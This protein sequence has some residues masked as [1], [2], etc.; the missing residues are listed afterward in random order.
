MR[1]LLSLAALPALFSTITAQNNH[2]FVDY[3]VEANPDLFPQCLAKLNM[4][5]PDC[6]SGPLS[7]NLVCDRSASPH[8]RATALVSLFT[9]EE[10]VNNT[11]NTGFGVPR[12]NLPNYQVWGEALHG[13]GRATFRDQGDFSWATSFPMP[14]STMAALNKT[15]IKQI[16]EIV[17]TQLRAYSNAGLGGI[18]V[19]SPNINTFRHPVWGRGQETPG[20]DPFLASV[21]G[22]EYITA[23]QGSSPDSEENLKIIATAKHFAGYDI[24]SWRNHSRLGNDVQ[25]T[26]QDLSEYYMPPFITAARD[27]RVRSVM[28]SYNAV[29]GLPS[30][31]NKFFLQTLLRE[32]FA[33]VEDGYVSGDCGAV[34]NVWNPHGYADDEAAASAA[35]IRAGTD[36]DC[37]T[38]YQF[39][40]EDSLSEE[41]LSRAEIE[42]GV[43]RLY[44]SLIRAGY[45]DG[46][47]A[48]YRD[49]S[50]GDVLETDGW[51]IAYEA[52][53]E[54]IVLLKNAEGTLPLSPE[55]RSVAVIGPWANVTTELQ[56]NYFGP[57]PY[58]ISPL[59]AFESSDLQVHYAFG[60]NV[61]SSSDSGF[62]AALT[63]ARDAD[64]ILFFGGIDNTIEAEAMD[65]DNITWPGNQL[66]L[67]A[68]LSQLHKP[69]IVTTLGGGQIDSSTLKENP[70]VHALLWAGYPGQSGG[71][72]IA[73]VITGKRAPAGRLVTTQYPAN[74][75]ETFSALDMSLRPNETSGNPGQTYM[76]YTGE[77]V[78]E[79]GHGLFYTT[80]AESANATDGGVLDIQELVTA[81]HDGYGRVEQATLL[82][83][84]VTV[85][86]TGKTT[87][88]YTGLVFANTTAGPEPRPKKWVVGF[89][90]LGAIEAG[91]EKVFNVP[92]TI[93]SVARTDEKGNRVLYP[94]K[95]ELALNNERSVVV[96]FE[97]KGDEVVLLAWP[98]ET[99]AKTEIL[100][101]QG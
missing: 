51:D 62:D 56:G 49:I 94:G 80:F 15:L 64:A 90:R 1:P 91:E 69:L 8:A 44:A 12:L 76:W 78:Y 67:I 31:A 28:C 95:Y 100:Q 32:T 29:N 13:V 68:Q 39:Y 17:S 19:Y 11:G 36:I 52:A 9:F 47:D 86:N 73:D 5:F 25:I 4:S 6:T 58:L 72:A 45:F 66:D 38:S 18:D 21:F 85:R 50:W 82:N 34:Y 30:C 61:S 26:Q 87:S 40:L 79:F 84:T 75:A 24:E 89:D 81:S 33:F 27:A 43:V 83:F 99:E 54:G 3:T 23:L 96:G 55:I 37:G 93:D 74:Y 35:S 88:D 77:A 7:Q 10:L 92:V 98:E 2:S 60:T 59:A 14:I 48:P 22:Y 42:R 63:A 97:L 65:R 46:P 41:M 16:G 101:V 71:H 53:V 57:A 20:E 70:N